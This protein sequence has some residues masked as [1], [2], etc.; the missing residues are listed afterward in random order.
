M[1]E[2]TNSQLVQNY[3]NAL[4]TAAFCAGRTKTHHNLEYAQEYRDKLIARGQTVPED[5]TAY[6]QGIF[7]GNGSF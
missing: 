5:S 4:K 2:L 7:N 1:K 3:C 6:A